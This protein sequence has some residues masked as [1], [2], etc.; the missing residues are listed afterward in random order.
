MNC[1]IDF[2]NGFQS[3]VGGI[4][5]FTVAGGMPLPTSTGRGRVLGTSQ[6]F[7]NPSAQSMIS[8]LGPQGPEGLGN[9]YWRNA[10][11]DVGPKHDLSKHA[12]IKTR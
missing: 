9:R 2:H 3:V 7:Q 12:Y 5:G 8:Q 6:Q 10:L 11:G 4:A 1:S